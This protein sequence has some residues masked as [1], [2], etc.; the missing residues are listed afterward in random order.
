MKQAFDLMRT[1]VL[2]GSCVHIEK[3][4]RVTNKVYKKRSQ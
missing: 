3:R 4:T 2:I 1:L